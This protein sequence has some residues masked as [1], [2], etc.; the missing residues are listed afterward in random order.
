MSLSHCSSS[1]NAKILLR[2]QLSLRWMPSLPEPRPLN[3]YDCCSQTSPLYMLLSVTVIYSP[4]CH[5][6]GG[7]P[8]PTCQTSF[9]KG[10]KPYHT[11]QRKIATLE[12]PPRMLHSQAAQ[13][14]WHVLFLAARSM[15]LPLQQGDM[16]SHGTPGKV[17]MLEFLQQMLYSQM[18][19]PQLFVLSP[20]TGAM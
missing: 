2:R 3:C 13:P 1:P 9:F 11:M 12:L 16:P 20:I 19:Q 7:M 17:A 10:G 6:F 15:Q 4:V 5:L 18:D 14:Q 8:I